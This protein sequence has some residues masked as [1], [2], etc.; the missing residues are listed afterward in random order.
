MAIFAIL[1]WLI[2][3]LVI[4]CLLS[5]TVVPEILGQPWFPIFRRGWRLRNRIAEASEEV[6]TR[7]VEKTL[8]QYKE[9]EDDASRVQP[10]KHADRSS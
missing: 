9:K 1:E 3:I 5:Q 6:T 4:G 8:D 7:A 10:E 2:A